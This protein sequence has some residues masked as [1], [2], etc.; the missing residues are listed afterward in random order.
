MY[1]GTILNLA[2][3]VDFEALPVPCSPGG[4]LVMEY[5]INQTTGEKGIVAMVT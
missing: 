4:K 5:L 2:H 1:G 3:F